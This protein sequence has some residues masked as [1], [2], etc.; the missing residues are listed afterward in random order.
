M[1]QWSKRNIPDAGNTERI[2]YTNS[3]IYYRLFRSFKTNG[4][5]IH[6]FFPECLSGFGSVENKPDFNIP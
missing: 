6:E 4:G 1:P 5:R 2:S 3:L